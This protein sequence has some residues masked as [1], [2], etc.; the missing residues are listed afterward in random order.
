M[1]SLFFFSCSL[2]KVKVILLKLTYPEGIKR[3]LQWL[4]YFFNIMGPK[5]SKRCSN[6]SIMCSLISFPPNIPH[7]AQW[8]VLQ[9]CFSLFSTICPC[10][11]DILK[12]SPNLIGSVTMQKWMGFHFSFT[13]EASAT[14]W[15]SPPL[16][17][18]LCLGKHFLQ[19]TNQTSYLWRGFCSLNHFPCPII[20]SVFTLLL[21][22]LV[23]TSHG[24]FT[25]FIS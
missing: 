24:E 18:I 22:H 14:Y 21:P 25:T 17:S 23:A 3:E 12:V 6:F 10:Q 19:P 20:F 2:E 1:K 13:I 4:H 9:I 11:L 16:Q 7:D 15:N 5:K 8:M